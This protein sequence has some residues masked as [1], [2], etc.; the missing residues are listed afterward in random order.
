MHLIRSGVDSFYLAING[1]IPVGLLAHLTATKEQAI[2]EPRAIPFTTPG[3]N[4]TAMM[5]PNGAP[6][7]YAFVW[8]T[9][10]LGAIWL[11]KG[12]A[13]K[14]DWNFF[15]KP[16]A[17][18]LLTRGFAMGTHEIL[19]HVGQ[20][21]GRQVGHSVNRIDYAIDIRADDFELDLD[22]FVAHARTKRGPYWDTKEK[23][24]STAVFT[25]RRLESAT[26]GRMPGRQVIVYDK[27]AEARTRQKAHFF[28]A[29]NIEQS[30]KAARVWRIEL[31]LGK[32]E[33]KERLKITTIDDLVHKL[34][35][36]L[37]D[38]IQNVRYVLPRQQ[39]RNVSRQ[40]LHPIWDLACDHVQQADL[41]SG[42]GELDPTSLL[43]ITKEIAIERYEMLITGNAAGLGAMMGLDEETAAG[44][45][46]DIVRRVIGDAV[47]TSSFHRSFARARD[48]RH[49]LQEPD[50]AS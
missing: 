37:I 34:K 13:D 20:I 23:K 47:L 19:R 7:S 45:L 9:G 24:G 33:L 26:V 31:R 21:G 35:S 17:T 3:T 14:P 30:D 42:I 10:V 39:D 6:G 46:P 16:H 41:L 29:W 43:R 1:I 36:V 5:V 44:R 49:L 28:K 12:T 11:C 4:L 2:S 40:K 8:D 22:C 50:D 18:A 27:T 48:K 38:L 25:G 15:A 32:R